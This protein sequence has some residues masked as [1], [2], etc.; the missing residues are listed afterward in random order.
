MNEKEQ[1]DKDIWAL[2]LSGSKKT[3]DWGIEGVE[4][5]KDKGV[6]FHVNGSRYKGNVI[7]TPSGLNERSYSATMVSVMYVGDDDP[8]ESIALAHLSINDMVK[9]KTDNGASIPGAE[10]ARFK[11]EFGFETIDLTN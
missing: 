1:I 5:V 7:L 4:N 2:I 8:L 11:D 9:A 3:S 10:I 6:C